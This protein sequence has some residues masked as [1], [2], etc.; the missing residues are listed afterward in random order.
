MF[1]LLCEGN[2]MA[3]TQRIVGCTKNTVV[4]FIRD[5]GPICSAYQDEVLRDLPCTRIEVDEIWSFIYAKRKNVPEAKS[6][7]PAAGDVWT[8]TAICADTRLL[9]AWRIGDR[10]AA[11]GIPFLEDLRTRLTCPVQ[12]TSDGHQVYLEAVDAV[13][14]DIDYA[15]LVKVLSDDEGSEKLIVKGGPDLDLIS[16]SYVE[17]HNLTIRMGQRRYTRKT[18]AFSKKLERHVASFAMWSLWYN[19]GRKH[20]TLKCTPAEAAGVARW[21]WVARDVI[22]LIEARSN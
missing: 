20:L 19:F 12:L 1:Q 3:S 16:T 10:T 2:S 7:P 18:N 5:A 15:M 11:T 8:W 9:A 14:D 13:F 21:Q 22:D 4:K 17:R 6:P